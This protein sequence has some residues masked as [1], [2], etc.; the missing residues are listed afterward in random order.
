[1]WRQI[2]RP[3]FISALVAGLVVREWATVPAPRVADSSLLQ[4]PA[5]AAPPAPAPAPTPA[6]VVVPESPPTALGVALG[7]ILLVVLAAAATLTRIEPLRAVLVLAAMLLV[8]GGTVLLRAGRG[9]DAITWFA[10]AF[11]LSLA[12]DIVVGL[13]MV[14]T[15]FWYPEIAAGAV[16][17]VCAIA[18][19]VHLWRS[20]RNSSSPRGH[21]HVPSNLWSVLRART[22]NTTLAVAPIAVALALWA[23]SLGPTDLT[24][25]T[26]LGVPV[27]LPAT[28]YAALVVA[29]LGAVAAITR[30]RPSA[31]LIAAYIG[32]VVVVLFATIPAIEAMPQYM[33]TYKHIGVTNLIEQ[34]GTVHPAVDIYNRWPGFFAAAAGFARVSGLND[35]LHFAGW[36]EPMFAALDALMVAAIARAFTDRARVVGWAALLF[37]ITNSTGQD[38]F[39]PQATAFVLSLGVIV[40][41]LRQLSDL[42]RIHR[43]VRSLAVRLGANVEDGDGT[44]T[45]ILSSDRGRRMSVQRSSPGEHY[46]A[47]LEPRWALPGV[48]LLDFA[49]VATH[50]LTP[51]MLVLQIAALTLV[52]IT[53]PRW[54]V[55][56]LALMAV[57]YLA[58]NLPFVAHEY[59]L[60]Q[61]HDPLDNA[62]VSA[63]TAHVPWETY[64]GLSLTAACLGMLG[65]AG[66][67]RLARVGHWRPVVALLA[68]ALAPFVLILGQ[69]YGGEGPIRV[70]LFAAPGF[71]ALLGWGIGTL[72]GRIQIAAGVLAVAVL[73]ALWL[74]TSLGRTPISVV[75][76]AEVHASQ[77]FYTH[78]PAG[79]VLVEAAPG[80]PANVGARYGL[81]S[82]TWFGQLQ[83]LTAA[84]AHAKSAFDIKALTKIV[85]HERGRAYLVFSPSGARYARYYDSPTPE[86]LAA[87]QSAVAL[88]LDFR[89]W[90][91]EGQTRIYVL[92]RLG[93]RGAGGG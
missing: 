52:G 33:W 40:L 92:S 62:S 79:S 50:Q 18:V 78:A 68:L 87:L 88:S 35:P 38:Y 58:P 69:S 75:S 21:L 14:W 36:A 54:L 72:T 42:D 7:I 86:S 32:T 57:A 80:F 56:A 37:T 45:P 61:L 9:S 1:M 53:R 64:H 85:R 82:S 8:P 4:V 47:P 59:G 12:I 25:L 10:I 49:L 74:P 41:V 73:T 5:P 20:V 65:L 22:G 3:L 31:W 60:L 51:Y 2:R 76:A 83:S 17:T 63:P 84:S 23:V 81:M 28:W 44:G 16:A 89:L 46:R 91:A 34:T 26:S 39:S 43:R 11:A 15:G 6:V 77:Y 71:A 30:D 66:A 24:H 29:L 19:A 93:L 90:H 67:F 27:G 13:G 70:L 55:G 48:L